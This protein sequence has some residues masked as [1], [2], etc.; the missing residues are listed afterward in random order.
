MIAI[1]RAANACGTMV[2]V[3]KFPEVRLGGHVAASTPCSGAV[4]S[5]VEVRTIAHPPGTIAGVLFANG[6]RGHAGSART[7]PARFRFAACLPGARRN[8][9]C[10]KLGAS[11]SLEHVATLP[12]G[13]DIVDVRVPKELC[14]PGRGS[15]TYDLWLIWPNEIV[16]GDVGTFTVVACP[17]T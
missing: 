15:W 13:T 1:S 5:T 8:Y 7:A 3:S 14:A 10:A 11:A 17:R 16:M 4:G 9:S 6:P 2:D 12:D